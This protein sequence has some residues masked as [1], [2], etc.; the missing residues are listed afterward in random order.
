MARRVPIRRVK[1]GFRFGID[2]D[3]IL[4][5]RRLVGEVRQL[6]ESLEPGDAKMHRLFPPAYTDDDEKNL[7]YQRLMRDELVASRVADLQLVDELLNDAIPADTTRADTT[8]PGPVV[9]DA[10]RLEALA[11]SVNSVRLVLGSLLGLDD[12]DD[13]HHR[14]SGRP[15]YE[16]YQFLSWVLDGAVDAL[17]QG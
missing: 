14:W 2:A 11:R 12:E 8:R 16:L 4:L 7:E 3:E 5:V 10:T 6:L 1:G 17:M 13:D 9:F 15:E